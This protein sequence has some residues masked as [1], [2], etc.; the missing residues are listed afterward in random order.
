ML[1][2]IN[3]QILEL[4]EILRTKEKLQSLKDMIRDE[5][6]IKRSQALVLEGM[7]TDEEKDV[8][9]LEGTSFSSIFLSLIG[10]KQSGNMSR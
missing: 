5:L 1:T 7:L 9:R 10:K 6:E 2:E 3:Q 8:I 4:K